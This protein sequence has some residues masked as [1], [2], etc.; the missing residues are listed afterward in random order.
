MTNL[1]QAWTQARDRLKA[2]KVDSPV[3]DAR[4]LVEAACDASRADIV[5][6]P[7]REV[8][9]EQAAVLDDYLER[10]SRREPVSRILG[11]KGF[12]KIMLEVTPAVLSPRPDTETVVQEA[13]AHFDEHRRFDVL[14]L[15]V[16]SGAILLAI[17][18]E[19]P[20]AR[21]LGSDV[22]EDALAV[23]RDNAARLGLEG[24]V[25]LLHGDWTEGL[26]A[27]SFDLVVSNPPYISDADMDALDPEVRDH[28][29]HL[30]LRGGPDGLDHYR[31]LAPQLLR[32]LRPGGRFLLE[33]GARPVRCG[34]A[35][36]A[37]SGRGRGA[38][39]EGPVQQGPRGV[40]RQKTLGNR[41][42]G[43]YIGSVHSTASRRPRG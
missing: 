16:G 41:R 33:I 13:L 10:R 42:L 40:G 15:G 30:A 20:L 11:R 23:A 27:D 14:D 29:P 18:A 5:T 12:W 32:V 28:D 38:H 8:A 25:A 43:R 22:S 4:L 26:A 34:G 37:P 1:V 35:A 6:D 9:P 39:G 3:I 21:G 17:L 19:R 7:Y 31:R 36:H 2:A 24:R